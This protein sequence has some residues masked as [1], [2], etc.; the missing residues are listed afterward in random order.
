MRDRFFSCRPLQNRGANLIG[1]RFARA[2][3]SGAKGKEKIG[4][5]LETLG[6]DYLVIYDI[7][8][9]YGNI[10]HIV[11]N[12]Q[13]GV[14][15]LE[16]K[17]HGGRVSVKNGHLLVNGHDPEKDFIAQVLNNTYWLKEKTCNTINVEVWIIAVLVFTNAFV[18]RRLQSKELRL[19]TKSTS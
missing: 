13:S 16:T 7:E 5:L 15:L 19:S 12:K 6:E 10:D 14:F 9:P 11:I 8:S 1:F 4:S 3:L 18:E 17:A 2:Y